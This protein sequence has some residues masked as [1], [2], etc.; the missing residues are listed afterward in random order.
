M[1]IYLYVKTHNITGLKYLGKTSSKTPHK[2]PGSGVYW[3]NHL[4]K[5]G[6]DYD[7]EILKECQTNQ[8]VAEW[9][10]Y[11]SNLWNVVA[12]DKWA[13][14]TEESGAGGDNSQFWTDTYWTKN[15]QVRENWTSIQK[16]KSYDE[17]YGVEKAQNIKNKQSNSLKGKVLNLSDEERLRRSLVMKL[18]NPSKNG[19]SIDTI[20]KRSNTFKERDCNKGNKNGMNT[21]PES[22]LVIAEKRSKL[23]HLKNLI[24]EEEVTVKNISKW[25]RENNLNS[26][27]VL[28]KFS[29]NK[30]VLDWIRISSK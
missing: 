23:H 25:A 20:K 30:P 18:N 9:G 28:C 14:L 6:Y 16:D 24:T 15:K 4:D 10:L 17:I 7:T 1:P 8:E 22:R 5:H 21:K 2:Y 29:Q 19:V 26:S 27:T 12:S 13:N 3:R 11:Y